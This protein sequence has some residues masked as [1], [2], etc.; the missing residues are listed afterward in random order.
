MVLTLKDINVIELQTFQAG[1]DGVK[2]VLQHV[3]SRTREPGKREPNLTVEALL[4]DDAEIF[5][6]GSNDPD[7]RLTFRYGKVELRTAPM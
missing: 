4:V 7:V 3:F 1:L 6:L 2:Y 5:C